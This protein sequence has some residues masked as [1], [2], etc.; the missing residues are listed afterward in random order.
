MLP[1]A[2]SSAHPIWVVST[3]AAGVWTTF[4]NDFH[5]SILNGFFQP[6]DAALSCTLGVRR[7]QWVVLAMQTDFLPIQ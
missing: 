1:G 4:A 3:D 6:V 2:S 5:S 7:L